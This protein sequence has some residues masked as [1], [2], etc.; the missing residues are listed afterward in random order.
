MFL[1]VCAQRRANA[2]PPRPKKASASTSLKASNLTEGILKARGKDNIARPSVIPGAAPASA[3]L[4]R[5]APSMV[6]IAGMNDK[7]LYLSVPGA[8]DLIARDT[9]P[10]PLVNT[11]DHIVGQL[12]LIGRTMAILEQRLT[13]TEN[14]LAGLSATTRGIHPMLPEDHEI[15]AEHHPTSYGEEVYEGGDDA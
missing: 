7:D 15:L 12:S 13:L 11:L 6:E 14:R 5:P 3:P 2:S 8:P 1:L 4:S 9:L 10:A